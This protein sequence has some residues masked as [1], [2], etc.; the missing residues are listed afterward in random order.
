MNEGRP[1]V[2]DT[3]QLIRIEAVHRGFLFQH[4]Y[5]VKA[6]LRTPGTDVISVI[7]ESDEDV[8][9]VRPHSRTYVQVK[10]RA[11]P[12]GNTDIAGALRR[13]D[14]YRRLHQSG[15]RSGNAVFVIATNSHLTPSLAAHTAHPSWPSDTFIDYPGGTA[16]TDPV[17]ST[18]PTSLAD[19]FQ[20]CCELAARLPYA[21]L[22]PETLVWKLAGTVMAAASG[23]APRTDHAF[24]PTELTGLFEQ[25]VVQL[26]D[27]PAPPTVYR[28]QADEPPLL[29]D[30]PLRLIIGY[31]GAGKTAWVSQAAL[32][33]PSDLAYYDV[34]E[35]PGPSLASGLARDL[36]ARFYGGS[37]GRLGEVL[38]PGASGL[39]VLKGLARRFVSEGRKLTIVLD[40]AHV[41]RPSDVEAAV[42]AAPGLNFALLGQPGAH[43]LELTQRL[44]VKPETLQGWSPDTVAAEAADMGCQASLTDCQA[45]IALTGGL[46][47][48]VQNA[49]AIARAEHRGSVNALSTQ[50]STLTHSTQTV[51]ELILSRTVDTLP[52]PTRHALGVLSLSDV[53]LSNDEIV[54][55]VTKSLG[56]DVRAV[57]GTLRELRTVAALEV[58]GGDHLK[59]HDAFRLL[60]RAQLA[61]LGA[62]NEALAYRNLRNTLLSSLKGDWS[63]PK[64]KLLLR[65]LAETEDVKTLVQFGTDELFHEMGLWPEI[66]VH[67]R[68]A[69]ASDTVA[70]ESRFWALDGIVFNA[71]REGG[72]ARSHIDHMKRLVADHA[73]GQEERLAVNLKEMNL[74]ALEGRADAAMRVRAEVQSE[75]NATPT[76]QRI[77]RY[78]AAVALYHTG[79]HRKA[80]SEALAIAQEYYGLL[81]LTPQVVMGRNAS[82]LRPLLKQ[83][84]DVLDH[85]KHLADCLDLYA[86]AMN[87]TG[88]DVAFARIHA[89]KFYDLAQAPES[90]IRLGQDLVDEFIGRYD[91]VGARQVFDAILLPTLQQLKLASYVIP[92]RSQYAVTL[93]Y[94]GD[95]DGAAAEMARLAPYESG[96]SP[97]GRFE[98]QRQRQLIAKL[99]HSPPPPQVQFS[100]G[101]PLPSAAPRR[102][103]EL[104]KLGRNELCFCGSGK[105]YKKCHG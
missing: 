72:N 68:A 75:L 11:G 9:I 89:M 33:A 16:S 44:G 54:A 80:A 23:A 85:C 36:A 99:R 57:A 2:V 6:L 71:M 50:L 31:S 70:P 65:V 18:S 86:K 74:L 15:E 81:G 24:H 32:H 27:F 42:R 52:G 58:F 69:A 46:P 67:L 104:R 26:Q 79:K 10:Y 82:D 60:G 88:E 96:L 83:S 101:L 105:K 21:L 47:L 34:R 78:N 56:I 48:Y 53:P 62:D 14:T 51:Q 49:L 29:T 7:I 102:N 25:L 66:D 17:I 100:P 77:F 8:E 87:A 1:A 38:L 4:L 63:Y 39:E 12:L 92:V 64:L 3:A 22:S 95:F 91:Y 5:A 43:I 103:E 40:N 30:A 61:A 59:I 20:L 55:I 37:G 19:A 97:S 98:L 76:S 93:A 73:L 35:M 84:D 90:L 94:G 13:F 28:T 45:L 41:P